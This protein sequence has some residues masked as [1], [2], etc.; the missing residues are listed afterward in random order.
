LAILSASSMSVFVRYP[1]L[2]HSRSDTAGPGA[3]PYSSAKSVGPTTATRRP[4]ARA[5]ST[6]VGASTRPENQLVV[7]PL[8]GCVAPVRIVVQFG[9]ESEGWGAVSVTSAPYERRMSSVG[10]SLRETS[11]RIPS[12]ITSTT[13]LTSCGPGVVS[14]D[15]SEGGTC[16]ETNGLRYSTTCAHE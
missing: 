15:P 1:P 7:T 8:T 6:I 12:T 13:C 11:S 9:Y 10:M 2:G 14:V 16:A 3:S 4:P 5:W